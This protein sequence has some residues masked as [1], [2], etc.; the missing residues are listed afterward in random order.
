MA[1]MFPATSPNAARAGAAAVNSIAQELGLDVLFRPV[2]QQFEVDLALLDGLSDS[3]VGDGP[4]SLCS[5]LRKSVDEEETGGSVVQCS[6]EVDT[7]ADGA[8]T[9]TVS[10]ELQGASAFDWASDR[11]NSKAAGAWSADHV[12]DLM[13]QYVVGETRPDGSASVAAIEADDVVLE[14]SFTA[15]DAVR[16]E[17]F[18]SL[19][20]LGQLEDMFQSAVVTAVDGADKA[21][22]LA[23]VLESTTKDERRTQSSDE[24]WTSQQ[25]HALRR[26]PVEKSA[27]VYRSLQGPADP[28]PYC[29][30]RYQDPYNPYCAMC[31]LN[32]LEETLPEGYEVAEA[33]LYMDTGF[34]SSGSA[35][36]VGC[37]DGYTATY[38]DDPT[39]VNCTL[40]QESLPGDGYMDR[41]RPFVF[42]SHPEEGGG[43]TCFPTDL[44]PM[45]YC[46]TNV[47]ADERNARTST[48]GLIDVDSNISIVC[49]GGYTDPDT[50]G[51]AGDIQCISPNA[52][53]VAY[54]RP[55]GLYCLDIDDLCG[56]TPQRCTKLGDE[57]LSFEECDAMLDGGALVD[58][59]NTAFLNFL[60]SFLGVVLDPP[61]NLS[62]TC[63]SIFLNSFFDD[64]ADAAAFRELLIDA[65]ESSGQPYLLFEFNGV[66]MN[67]TLAQF[68][69]TVPPVTTVVDTTVAETTVLDTTV[70]ETTVLD[71]TVAATTVAAT[72]VAPA[73]TV[74]PTT[75]PVVTTLN[76]NAT[77]VNPNATTVDPNATTVDPNATTV[78]PN[79]TTTDPD[80]TTA[81][82][83]APP[84]TTLEAFSTFATITTSTGSNVTVPPTGS[85][86]GDVATTLLAT[87]AVTFIT[88]PAVTFITTPA[89]TTVDPN[90]TTRDPN[91]TTRDPNATTRDPNATTRDP[92]ATTRDPD[93][94]TRDPNATTRDP[95]ATTRDPNATEAPTA[96]TG[97]TD[98]T[99]G[100][101]ATGAT[102]ATAATGATDAT[103]ATA[104]TGVTAATEAT[105]GTGATDVGTGGTTDT[106]TTTTTTTADPDDTRIVPGLDNWAFGLILAIVILVFIALIVIIVLAAMG[107]F[108][109]KE[110]EEE[111]DPQEEVE[112]PEEKEED[113]DDPENPDG[114]F[115]M[116]TAA[117]QALVGQIV[118]DQVPREMQSFTDED[119][120]SDEVS[121]LEMGG[122]SSTGA[123]QL[124]SSI[125]SAID[126]VEPVGE[127]GDTTDTVDAPD[128]PQRTTA[129]T[130]A[131]IS[132][133]LAE[134]STGDDEEGSTLVTASTTE[135]VST[136]DT[137]DTGADASG[138]SGARD[139]AY[140]E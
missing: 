20:A 24:R 4:Q 15:H 38:G 78:D 132:E 32:E 75:T 12:Q 47:M 61:P 119:P 139:D 30:S 59:F 140:D 106:T 88:T 50:E 52:S 70:A 107:K 46:D 43:L 138:G 116:Q 37:A 36:G 9:A 120:T 26:A 11:T 3:A 89:A 94:T 124:I 80:A 39:Q 73:T 55:G 62:P 34:L 74:N 123:A 71:T 114:D 101:G 19:I 135:D 21:D 87:T 95:N 97:P 128:D 48:P 10:L 28:D 1:V 111:E 113:P 100:T 99:G 63:G 104:G 98:A 102:D 60:G 79:A 76:P 54:F 8:C 127:M 49:K 134:P 67:F 85:T 42:V 31:E 22:V 92:N 130:D 44:L 112:D 126:D 93:A 133:V 14:V 68:V 23:V 51:D 53:E 57:S 56:V 108:K 82:P 109:K 90:A 18:Q 64:P 69:S 5:F 129:A 29:S 16:A 7:V 6:V 115:A 121:E 81:S 58:A 66:Q 72:T 77:T 33:D 103:G 91:A 45:Q 17:A 96:G 25:Q 40:A 84:V 2:S 27:P 65:F 117:A 137:R 110:E 35:A 105:V 136:V 83:T 86:P 13:W 131:L 41:A 118:A 122:E 125:I